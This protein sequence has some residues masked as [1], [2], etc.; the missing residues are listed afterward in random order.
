MHLNHSETTPQHTHPKSVRKKFVFHKTSPWCSTVQIKPAD[1]PL[2]M[3]KTDGIGEVLY[4][5]E[6]C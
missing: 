6:H 4:L 3:R 1:F 5:R 2:V